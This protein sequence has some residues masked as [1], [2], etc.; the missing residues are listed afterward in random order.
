MTTAK[1]N[2]TVIAICIQEPSEDGSS[3]DLG[4]IQGDELRFLHQAFITDTIGHA[5]ETPGC[6]VQLYYIDQPDRRRLVEIV[7]AYI[8]K[9]LSGKEAT[10]FKK[11]FQSFKLKKDSWGVRLKSVFSNCFKAGYEQVLVIGSR[12]PTVHAPK[13]KMA[14]KMLSKGDAVFGPTPEG[15]YYVIGMSKGTK[16][17][18]A[19]F[20]WKSPTIYSSVSETFSTKGLAWSELEIWYC[21]ESPDEL[22]LM[23]RD[24]NQY[25]FEGD[26]TSARETEVVM[27]R[28]LAKLG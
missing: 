23:V 26:D 3:M 8:S 18:L 16:I 10:A 13:L 9:K 7:T 14:I 25:R 11:R 21:V 1:K 20:D 24:I 4:A 22:E 6:D 28:I 12:T 17:D 2:K 19:E 5:L 27:E 15:R